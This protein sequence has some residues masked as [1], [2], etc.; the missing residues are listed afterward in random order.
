MASLAYVVPGVGLDDDELERRERIA[1]DLVADDVT[2]IEAGEGPL[3]IESTVEEEWSTV[4]VMRTVAAHEAE[5]DAFVIG[6]FGDP[7]LAAARELTDTPVVGPAAASFYTAVQLADRFSCLTILESTK[8]FTR[9]LIHDY[10]LGDQLA[11]VPVVE[12]P[13][14]DIDHE[15]NA[16]VQDMIDAGRAAV[17]E[18][19]AEALVPGCMSLS[20]MQVHDEI[21]EA[22]GVPFIDPVTAS[23]E[24]ASMWARHG[25][26]HSREAYPS[27]DRSKLDG[28]LGADP[29]TA[30]DD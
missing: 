2:V 24:T 12:A 21:A 7:G 3:S 17:T 9:R 16:I 20:F 11:S 6:C 29:L 10:G 4:G 22:V 26:T 8:P 13:V 5:I 19:G 23:L 1:N 14:L 27:A 28:L 25:I 18:D 30:D 15:S